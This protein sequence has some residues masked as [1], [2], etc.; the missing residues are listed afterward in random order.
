M[1]ASLYQRVKI[2]FLAAL[3]APL[4][5]RARILDGFCG[6]DA[7]LRRE[8]ESLLEADMSSA[9]ETLAS[10]GAVPQALKPG[11]NAGGGQDRPL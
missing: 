7:D 11:Q 5:E 6:E 10:P 8:V 2:A 1:E 3:D 4:G 9:R